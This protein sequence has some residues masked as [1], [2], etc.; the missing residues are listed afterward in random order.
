MLYSRLSLISSCALVVASLSGCDDGGAPDTASASATTGSS[1]GT[2]GGDATGDATGTTAVDPTTTDA[3]GTT[4]GGPD[5]GILL[6]DQFSPRDIAV[7]AGY[8]YF[9]AYDTV[10]RIPVDGGAVEQMYITGS[11]AEGTNFIDADAERFVWTN[12]NSNLVVG[13]VYSCPHAGCPAELNS[14]SSGYSTGDIALSGAIMAWASPSNAMVY[15]ALGTGGWTTQE[16]SAPSRVAV[17]GADV[18]WGGGNIAYPKG[19]FKCTPAPNA[20]CGF[21]MIS[22]AVGYPLA[23][24]AR[25]EHVVVVA[26]MG[27][28]HMGRDG[29]GLVKLADLV[30]STMAFDD[31]VTDGTDVYWADERQ[32]HG[33]QIDAC[34]PQL[35]AEAASGLRTAGLGM[36]EGSVYWGTSDWIDHAGEIRRFSR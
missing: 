26:E 30:G 17:D 22:D 23:I 12:R 24:A 29:S 21:T 25:G 16:V 6:T 3:S 19:V 1:G 11:A 20:A 31:I 4:T 32:L 36:D 28:F 7:A 2:T 5:A 27:V 33:C 14:Y 9:T 34:T 8:V 15:G 13:A 35:I 18:F 10:R